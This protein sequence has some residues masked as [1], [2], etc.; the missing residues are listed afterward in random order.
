MNTNTLHNL[1]EVF[2]KVFENPG[3]IISE[4]TTAND[5]ALWDSLTHMELIAAVEESFSIQFSLNEVMNFQSVGDLLRCI[6]T[7]TG[8]R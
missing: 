2:R 6:Q 3:L 4:K 5:I 8:S 1:Q 7:K